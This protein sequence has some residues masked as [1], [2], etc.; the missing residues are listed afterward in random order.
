M[1][2]FEKFILIVFSIFMIVVS[3]FAILSSAEMIEASSVFSKI[4]MWLVTNKLQV[5][6]L[7]VVDITLSLVGIFSN[8]ES[9]ESIKSGLAIKNESGTVYITRDTFESII[10][11]VAKDFASLRNVKVSV[12]IDELGISAN[13]Y[14]YILPDTVVPTLTKKLQDNIKEAIKTQTTVEIKEANIKI[15]GVYSPTDKK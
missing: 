11:N 1:K 5:I 2:G 8:A 6:I 12:N 7:G 15:K 9:E 4:N 14:V 10:L 13:I 3:V